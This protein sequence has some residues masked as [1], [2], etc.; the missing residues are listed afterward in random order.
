MDEFEPRTVRVRDV[1]TT[2]REATV[3][4][5]D[6]VVELY[7][8]LTPDDLHRRFFSGFRPDR[9]FV[10]RWLDRS[11]TGGIV[12]VA[13]EGDPVHGRVVSDAGY[14]PTGPDTAE[15]AITVAPDRR[16]WLG[17][18]VLDTLVEHAHQHGIADLAAEVLTTNCGMLAMLRA[19]GCAFR[20]SEDLSTVTALIGTSGPTPVWPDDGRRPRVLIE[21]SPS[22]WVGSRAAMDAGMSVLACPGPGR[23]RTHPCPLLHGD[24]CPLVDEADA[25]IVALP[26][27]AATTSEI[28]DAHVASGTDVPLAVSAPLVELGDDVDV[29]HRFRL[30]TGATGE[31]A[32]QDVLDAIAAAAGEQVRRNVDQ[33]QRDDT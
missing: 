31:R 11:G 15:L 9:H 26:R 23:G 29:P 4:D 25:V 30:D 16:G 32:V 13:V 19:R 33:D 14:V 18:F 10:E 28:L 17:P 7:G 21:G 20:P 27:S 8:S 24:R 2:V 22:S 3:A 6:R 5:V 1:T 12:L